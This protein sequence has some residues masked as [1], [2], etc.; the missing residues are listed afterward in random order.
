MSKASHFVFNGLYI[1]AWLIFIGLS[2]EAGG[3]LVNF[4]FSLF[5]PEFIPHLYQKLDLT[6]LYKE[7]RGAFFGIYGFLLSIAMLKA[8]LFY[9]VIRL[10]HKMDVSNPFSAFVSKQISSLSY[11]VLSIGLLG[12]LGRELA[13]KLTPNGYATEHLSPFWIDSQAFVLM[14][15]ILYVI[16]TIFRKGVELQNEN[17]LTV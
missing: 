6:P 7:S 4:F 14:G 13:G 11:F 16:A 2:M 17:D 9:N 3:L 12:Y 1:V 8:C 10:M 15:A 5:K